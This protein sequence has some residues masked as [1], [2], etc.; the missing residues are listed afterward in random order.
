MATVSTTIKLDSELKQEAQR[1]F[2]EYGLSLSAAVT[3]F[4]R[5]TVR[6]QAI[7]FRVGE[8]IEDTRRPLT[9]EEVIAALEEASAA[10]K[11]PGYQES[12]VPFDVM[13]KEMREIANGTRP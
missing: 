13:M 4:L 9:R 7:P 3:M 10:A 12:L 8:T 1:F 2:D 5:Q 11:K 6:E